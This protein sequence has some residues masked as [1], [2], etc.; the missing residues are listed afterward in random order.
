MT[1]RK[2]KAGDAERVRRPEAGTGR[3]PN[4][5]S[6]AAAVSPAP[7]T[8]A[9]TAAA[10]KAKAQKEDSVSD[11]VAHAV[12]VGY[13]VIAEN[14]RQGREAAAR[15]RQGEY[16]LR[17][18]PGDLEVASQRLL[19]LARELSTTTF[20]VCERLIRELGEQRA[21]HDRTEEVPKFRDT[22]PFA[23]L[24]PSQSASA[25][26]QG[27]PQLKVTVRVVGAVKALVHTDALIRPRVPTAASDITA[28]P[29]APNGGQAAPITD[30]HFQMDASVEGVVA[31]VTPPKGQPPGVYS[32]IV[33]AKEDPLP[34]GVL[35]IEL[36]K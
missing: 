35:T 13:D 18:A 26:P 24:T 12:K 20:D 36:L 22:M 7:K 34:L 32:G 33:H 11:A 15:F 6:M 21:P 30:V 1:I 25:A 14:I 5:A 4:R 8:V 16:R 2:G 27:P 28:A 29:L 17:D 10:A 19:R 9:A 23:S 3:A 31:V